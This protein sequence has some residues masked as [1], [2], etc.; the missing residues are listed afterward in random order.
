[1]S[2]AHLFL[3]GASA[4]LSIVVALFFAQRWRSSG[5]RFFAFFAVAFGLLATNWTAVALTD[6]A[7]ESRQWVYVFRLIAFVVIAAGIVDKNR[8]FRA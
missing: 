2:E 4:V 1:M 5:D 8:R 6:P 3:L 7:T